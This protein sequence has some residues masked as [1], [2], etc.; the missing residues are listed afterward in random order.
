MGVMKLAELAGLTRTMMA[1]EATVLNLPPPQSWHPRRR[2]QRHHPW[3][4]R[5][6]IHRHQL[7]RSQAALALLP[8]S[9]GKDALQS[10]RLGPYPQLQRPRPRHCW[11]VVGARHEVLLHLHLTRQVVTQRMMTTRS[12][13]TPMMTLRVSPRAGSV[14]IEAVIQSS[15]YVYW[16]KLS[17]GIGQI[18]H[19]WP[20]PL[21]LNKTQNRKSCAV[22]C[23]RNL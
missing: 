15:H 14:N 12:K 2:S 16:I 3:P 22:R 9:R 1:T 8:Q 5:P 23:D 7:Q 19:Y 13:H 4:S 17:V 6:L 11:R 10:H 20:E 18:A 21:A